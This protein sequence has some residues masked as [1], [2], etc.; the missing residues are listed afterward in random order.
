[1]TIFRRLP[2]RGMASNGDCVI[3]RRF[4][5]DATLGNDANSGRSPGQAWQ[6]IAKV[7]ASTF[8]PGDQIL[9][10]RGETWAGTTLIPAF[11]GTIG[12]PIILSAYGSGA[13]P[14]IDGTGGAGYGLRF[15][16]SIHV[17]V[18]DLAIT[19]AVGA[20]HVVYF[21]GAIY[22]TIRDCEIYGGGWAGVMVNDVG[23][24]TNQNNLIYNNEIRNPLHEGVYVKNETAGNLTSLTTIQ[25]NY[26]HGCGDEALQNTYDAPATTAPVFSYFIGNECDGGGADFDGTDLVIDKN[27]FYGAAGA[28][29]NGVMYIASG[30]NRALI[31]NNLIHDVD[32]DHAFSSG[33]IYVNA[34]TDVEIYH[35]TVYGITNTTSAGYGI[36]FNNATTNASVKNNCLSGNESQMQWNNAPAVVDYNCVFGVTGK[37]GTNAVTL[38]PKLVNPG[39]E[40]FHLQSDSPCRGAGA[41]GTGVTDDFDGVTRGSPPD[42]GAYE[43]VP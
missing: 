41:T 27:E 21:N 34:G 15:Q 9:F 35:N 32:Q 36:F 10:K 5:V 16:G 4:F 25:S 2:F 6:T 30:V 31:I 8:L 3:H 39:A 7:N 33:G 23:G 37:T 24:R 14:I 11:T 20:S 13:A 12:Q 19:N 38:D 18:R 43:Y 28:I 1:M 22:C 40:N 42:I 29:A 26:I 17:T